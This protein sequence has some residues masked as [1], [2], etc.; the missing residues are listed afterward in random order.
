MG[1]LACTGVGGGVGARGLHFGGLPAWEVLLRE[2]ETD[3]NQSVAQRDHYSAKRCR[4]LAQSVRG[5][6]GSSDITADHAYLRTRAG[7]RHSPLHS[8]A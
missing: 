5:E 2:L 4:V 7:L 8:I 6:D 1:G 3:F